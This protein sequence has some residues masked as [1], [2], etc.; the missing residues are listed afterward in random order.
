MF[1]VRFIIN[2]RRSNFTD[3]SL[4]VGA[5]FKYHNMFS[6]LQKLLWL[7][8]ILY[9]FNFLGSANSNVFS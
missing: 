7:F 9:N 2:L 3:L 5:D 1:S 8:D 4:D 6:L